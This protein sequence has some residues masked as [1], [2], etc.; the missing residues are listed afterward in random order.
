MKYLLSY[1]AFNW[2]AALLAAILCIH[3]AVSMAGETSAEDHIETGRYLALAANCAGCHTVDPDAPFA[4]GNPIATSFGTL[5][6]PNITPSA[7][8]GIGRWTQDDFWNAM[9][10]GK[11]PDGSLLYPAFPYP[12]YTRMTRSDTDAIYAY[13]M[14]LPA[15]D[16]PNRP[17]ELRFPYNQRSL[18]ALWRAAYFDP[19]TLEPD[20]SQ[21]EVWNRGRYLVKGPG[22]CAA[23]HTPRNRWTAGDTG[24]ELQ[25]ATMLDSEWYATPLTGDDYGL[26]NWTLDDIVEL[27]R[28][29]TSNQGTA[30]GPMA[31]VVTGSTQH[32]SDNDLLAI[33]TYLKTL[34][35]SRTAKTSSAPSERIMATGK[36]LY[37]QHCVQCHRASG[38]GSPPAW[39][40]LAGNISV[41]AESPGN[42]VL[43]ILNG[44]YAPATHSNPRPHGMPPYRMLSDGD[45]AALT[46]YIRNS[47]GNSASA[48][49]PHHVNQLR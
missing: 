29:G 18:L 23:C 46:T 10:N 5:Y 47:W 2:I 41:L 11:A 32:L 8:H 15:V 14:S 39:P 35:P 33:A 28:S 7:E 22:H 13:L 4:G 37:T 21:D 26:G 49:G 38:E 20:P 36:K 6:G 40:P 34:P 3:P 31:A 12:Q 9:H 17:H 19:G 42:T 43:K 44:G 16:T 30:A 48:V 45:I 25:G 27:L 24:R 1:K